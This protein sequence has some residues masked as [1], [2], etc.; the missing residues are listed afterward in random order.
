MKRKINRNLLG[1]ASLA[2][3]LTLGLT[4]TVCFQLIQKQ[5]I[6]DLRTHVHILN[7]S[8][9]VLQN[10]EENYDPAQDQ[11]RITVV[12]REGDVL[13]E[14]GADAKS[15]E[16][17]LARPEIQDAQ[18]TGAGKAVRRSDTI[19]TVTFYYAESQENGNIIRVARDFSY[20]TK[21][22]T[23]LIPEIVS[24]FA[25]IFALC[26][27]LG[28]YMTK[29]FIQPI[30]TLARD[31][32]QPEEIQTYPE[33]QPFIETINE[34][35]KAMKHSAKLRQEFTA[36]VSHELK[37]PLTSVSG[38]A[39]LIEA[40]IAT[41]DDTIRFAGEI[42]KNSKRLLNLINDI[43][44]LSQLDSVEDY[45]DTEQVDLYEM[46]LNC[47]DMLE[48]QAK[49]NR[50]A[51]KVKGS[52][53]R[54]Q[55]NRQMMEELIFNLCDNA[56]RYN[57]PGGE[58]LLTVG[59]ENKK[60]FLCV[61]DTGIGIPEKDRERIFERF[62]RVDKSRSKQT[63]GTGLGLAI[64]KHIAALHNAR[65]SVQSELGAGTEI[66][67]EFPGQSDIPAGK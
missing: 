31:I 33:I 46:A 35:H 8:E 53:C 48:M 39:E 13:Y 51:V 57:H 30:E 29:R 9:Y 40:G 15:M 27:V 17:H 20:F 34:Q 36:N 21:V 25:G 11:L 66:K 28:H 32:G 38:Y 3:F 42:H 59:E 7:S 1:I 47:R 60:V 52:S 63:G 23:Y 2:I 18:R 54:L 37:T 43:L 44:R 61:K 12:S 24:V 50:V 41:G 6:E 5:I 55:A 16:N 19:G 26:I 14:S 62:Y 22:F 67:I 4:M 58:A 49:K 64:V 56:I 45:L 65:I 10:L